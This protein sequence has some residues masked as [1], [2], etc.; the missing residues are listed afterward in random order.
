MTMKLYL[1]VVLMLDNGDTREDL[2]L[3]SQT[4]DD[5]KLADQIRKDFE[6]GKEL[7]ISVLK[8]MD[9]EKIIACKV[10]A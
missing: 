10:T 5:V 9:D 3:P 1:Q 6:E 7:L 2:S 4:D 8:A